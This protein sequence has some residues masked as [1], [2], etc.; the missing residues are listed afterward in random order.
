MAKEDFSLTYPRRSLVRS[1]MRNAGR[2]TAGLLARMEVTG[3]DNFPPEGGPLI[4]VGN[5]VAM[6]EVAMMAVYAPWPVEV[7]GAD[8]VPLYPAF[9]PMIKTYGYIP[10][11]RGSMDRKGMKMALD[12]LA[13]GGVIGIFP[14]GGIWEPTLN[15]A[16]SGVA[17][18]SQKSQA[19]LLPIGFGGTQD[20][21]V[22]ILTLKRPNIK[23]NIGTVMPPVPAKMPGK[24]RKKILA[25]GANTIMKEVEKLIPPEEKA[26]WQPI[27]EESFE[28]N[29]YICDASGNVISDAPMISEGFALAKF[30]HRPVLLNTMSYNLRL[31]VKPLKRLDDQPDAAAVAQAA[32]TVLDYLDQNPHFLTYRFGNREGNAMLRGLIQLRDLTQWAAVRGYRVAFSPIRRYRL[33]N[34]SEEIVETR[35]G[36]P[37]GK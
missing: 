21:L 37:V 19:P 12:I 23:M 14:E 8:D 36:Q 27:E 32:Q 4:L 28:F 9:A 35:I 16:R 6:L 30:F 15:Q 5:H 24:D 34:S 1:I 10:I 18:L 20:A 17:W 33:Q 22:N 26:N 7:M 2:A 31:P 11:K 3:R 13:Q 29:T 25:E